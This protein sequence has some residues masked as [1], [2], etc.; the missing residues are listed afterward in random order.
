MSFSSL[1]LTLCQPSVEWFA[2]RGETLGRPHHVRNDPETSDHQSNDRFKFEE[3][4]DRV[5]R[6]EQFALVV[7][8]SER[9]ARITRVPTGRSDQV[10]RRKPSNSQL[11]GMEGVGIGDEAT[12]GNVEVERAKD[13]GVHGLGSVIMDGQDEEQKELSPSVQLMQKRKQVFEVQ[14]ALIRE[15]EVFNEKE[16]QFRAMEEA[17][18]VRDEEFQS[19]MVDH[20]VWAEE[21]ERL[22]AEF[23]KSIAA[24]KKTR[25]TKE[26][27]L[28]RLQRQL[29]DLKHEKSRLSKQLSN[30]QEYEQLLEKAVQ[31]SAKLNSVPNLLERYK[32]L[33]FLDRGIAQREHPAAPFSQTSTSHDPAVLTNRLDKVLNLQNTL[34]ALKATLLEHQSNQGPLEQNSE[35]DNTLDGAETHQELEHVINSMHEE[36]VARGAVPMHP[37]ADAISKLDCVGKFLHAHQ[38]QKDCLYLSGDHPVDDSCAN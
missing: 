25:S 34:L 29:E 19:K 6:G 7:E 1:H 35:R 27:E 28:A 3:R 22:V 4:I 8:R 16:E 17:L 32:V 5:T 12:H 13:D 20:V 11:Q 10:G 15:K 23:E 30:H 2:W 14:E 18:K 26:S 36:V 38:K 21:N 24:E 31:A 9:W 37:I 33:R